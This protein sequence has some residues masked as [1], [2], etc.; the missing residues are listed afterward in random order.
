MAIKIIDEPDIHLTAGEHARLQREWQK[1]C[2]YTV[3]P[4]T[5]ED[6]VRR[7]K[8][9]EEAADTLRKLRVAEGKSA[10]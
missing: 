10:P 4:P 8:A 2:A 6:F 9:P 3:N 1:A 7:K 5:F